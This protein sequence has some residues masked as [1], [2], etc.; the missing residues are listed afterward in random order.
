MMTSVVTDA[1][2]G[3]RDRALQQATHTSQP[4]KQIQVSNTHSIIEVIHMNRPEYLHMTVCSDYGCYL[5]LGDSGTDPT[6]PD[7]LRQK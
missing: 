2:R 7:D 5:S 6:R 4:Q 1:A 3:N